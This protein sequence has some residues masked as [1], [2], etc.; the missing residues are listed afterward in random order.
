MSAVSRLSFL[1]A[2]NLAGNGV[3]IVGLVSGDGITAWFGATSLSRIP[4]PR[5]MG[6]IAVLLLA[7]VKLLS[8]SRV[9]AAD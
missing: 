5:I 9:Q 7:T 3:E 1:D 8:K 6:V 2:V 4:K